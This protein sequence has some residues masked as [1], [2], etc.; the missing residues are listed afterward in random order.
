MVCF[1][2]RW[3][4]QRY[5]MELPTL[6]SPRSSQVGG[7]APSLLLPGLPPHPSSRKGRREMRFPGCPPALAWESGHLGPHPDLVPKCFCF[8]V[9]DY[10]GPF[11]CVTRSAV[12]S[13]HLAIRGGRRGS[14]DRAALWNHICGSHFLLY[15]LLVCVT[16]GKLLKLS[17]PEFS[18]Q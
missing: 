1:R 5:Y 15:H 12:Q 10:A 2:C 13:R 6:R 11:Q 18:H 3:E 8:S 17:E 14:K 16:F 9:G 7:L 4:T